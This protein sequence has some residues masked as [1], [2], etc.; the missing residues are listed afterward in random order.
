MEDSALKDRLK[1]QHYGL[2]GNHSSVKV[3][4][5]TKKSLYDEGYCYKQKFYGISSHLCCQ[6]TPSVGY[7]MNNCVYCWRTVQYSLKKFEPIDSPQ[8]IYD[9][10]IKAQRRLI[11]G[12]KGEKRTNLKK[13]Q[14]AQNPKHFAISLSGEPTMYPKL[15]EFI[16]IVHKNKGT[17]FLVTNGMLPEVLEKLELPTQLYLSLSTPKKEL[18][19]KIHQP[20]MKDGWERLNSSLTVLNS[21]KDRTRTTLRVTA[22]KDLNMSEPDKWAELIEKAAPKFLEIKAYMFLGASRKFLK[23]ENMPRHEDITRFAE[24]LEAN[25]SYKYIDEKGDSRVV[26]MM[27]KDSKDRIMRF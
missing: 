13:W 6:M 8:T 16:R 9:E 21:L 11:S 24:Q 5:W 4:S 20:M 25:S 27:K 10:S 26:L 15:S 19:N 12:F 3:C 18:F 23:L 2:V 7:C 1:I 17:T 14:E 22:I